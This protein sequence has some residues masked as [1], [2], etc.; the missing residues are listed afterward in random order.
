MLNGQPAPLRCVC[1]S[2]TLQWTVNCTFFEYNR[3]KI[4]FH[5]YCCYI[6]FCCYCTKHTGFRSNKRKINGK[7]I[8]T[9]DQCLC[10]IALKLKVL[11]VQPHSMHVRAQNTC[12]YPIYMPQLRSSIH[13]ICVWFCW[14]EQSTT[15]CE[16]PR[17]TIFIHIQIH[18][19]I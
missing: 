11:C 5:G 18:T 2:F 1:F 12:M 8:S 6:L 3:N 10:T 15:K 17:K 16:L 9:S 4:M 7:K 14:P 19:Y 13:F